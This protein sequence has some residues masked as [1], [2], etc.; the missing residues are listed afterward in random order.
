[1]IESSRAIFGVEWRRPSIDERTVNG[2]AV[3]WMETT[4]LVEDPGGERFMPGSLTR[5]VK[6]R[7]DRMKLYRGGTEHQ[8]DTAIG[9]PLAMDARHPDGLFT[10]WH[11]A[12][13]PAGDAALEEIAEGMLD[14]FSIGFRAI[15]TQRAPD[16]AREVMEAELLEVQI[17]PLGAYD[18]ARVMEVRSPG[19]PAPALAELRAWLE[20]HPVPDVDRSPLPSIF[21][22]R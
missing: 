12:K 13:T 15:R 8:R 18:G 5:S 17:L 2:I 20:S 3:P 21:R 11:I 1:M 4:Y 14:A 9:R 6:A 16:G 7:G 22:A 10:A 19:Q